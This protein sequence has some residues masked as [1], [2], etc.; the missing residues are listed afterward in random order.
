MRTGRAWLLLA[1]A[2][3]LAAG[4]AH[5]GKWPD[6]PVRVIVPFA[7][8]G[9]TDVVARLMSPR[10]AEEFGQQFVVDNRA[11]AG[12]AIGAEM[13][14][15]A[16]PD[17]YTISIIASSYPS[18]AAL[19]KL[20]YDPIKGIAPISMITMG[21]FVLAV[22]P[23]V[24]A[25]DLKSFLELARAKPGS[26]SFGSSGTGGVPHL[27][28]EHFRQ[29]TNTSMVHVPYKGDAPAIADLLGGHIQC[30]LAGPLV[31]APQMSAGKLRGLAVTTEQRSRVMP[32]LPA[33]SE[34]VPGYSAMTWF[35]MWAP[36]GTPKE[37]VTQLNQALARILN[38]SDMQERLRSDGMEAA[39]STPEQFARLMER[40]IAKWK[41]VVQIGKI[42]VD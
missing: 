37:I 36:A 12:G 29:M 28:F 5:A 31:M 19:Y 11:G 3:S 33:I 9:A 35:G 40:D 25:R 23:S 38:R 24:N 18:N 8:G 39:H 1:F 41:T 17:G 14:A 4:F 22:H 15:R 2:G 42:K 32:D 27:A 26:L 16:T 20:P 34:Q 13:A 30:L 10:L 21:P 6:R 7:P